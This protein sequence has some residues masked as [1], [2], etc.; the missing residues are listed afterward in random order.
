MGVGEGPGVYCEMKNAED[1]SAGSRAC[2]SESGGPEEVADQA[3]ADPCR[4]SIRGFWR[5]GPARKSQE[6]HAQSLQG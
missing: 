6:A 2:D 5:A 3:P 4:A 1:L